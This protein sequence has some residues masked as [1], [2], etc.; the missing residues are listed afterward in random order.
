MLSKLISLL[1][2]LN[3]TTAETLMSG[4]KNSLAIDVIEQAKDVYF[5]KIVK[6]IDNVALPDVYL[7]DGKGYFIDNK[8]ILDM[9]PDDVEFFTDTGNNAVVF[10]VSD[11]T[12]TFYC[13]HF[14]YKELLFV[15]TG[16]ITV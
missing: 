9:A 3:M 14:R 12:G 5:N 11:F 8:F 4:V 10:K 6:M 15:A 7:D 13:D 16:S 2:L 1:C